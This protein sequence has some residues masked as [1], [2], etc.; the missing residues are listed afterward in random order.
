VA[1]NGYSTNTFSRL[2]LRSLWA[3]PQMLKH[4]SAQ[5]DVA[6]RALDDATQELEVALADEAKAVRAASDALMDTAA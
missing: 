2:P 3:Q 5:M 1:P 6:R 4:L